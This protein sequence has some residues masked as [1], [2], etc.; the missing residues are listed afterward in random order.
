MPFYD[1]A[2]PPRQPARRTKGERVFDD[3]LGCLKKV[4]DLIPDISWDRYGHKTDRVCDM[5]DRAI[6]KAEGRT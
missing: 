2:Y 1:S 5:V 4:R 6:A 3:L